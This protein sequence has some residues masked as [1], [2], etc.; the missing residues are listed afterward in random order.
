MTLTDAGPAPTGAGGTTTAT[1][2]LDRTAK[3]GAFT[4]IVPC[5]KLTLVV[6]KRPVP[7][8][9]VTFPP[10]TGPLLGL[11]EVSVGAVIL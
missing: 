6:F 11:R 5:V 1:W 3:L 7:V 2:V 8:I 10:V 9:V 4:V